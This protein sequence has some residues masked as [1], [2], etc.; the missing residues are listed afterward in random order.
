MPMSLLK[1]QLVILAGVNHKNSSLLMHLLI[2]CLFPQ[3]LGK[4][5][6]QGLAVLLLFFEFFINPSKLENYAVTAQIQLNLL[7]T[8]FRAIT[9]TASGLNATIGIA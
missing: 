5:Y 2:I 3:T 1:Q 7:S 6:Y 4:F 9:I 8:P